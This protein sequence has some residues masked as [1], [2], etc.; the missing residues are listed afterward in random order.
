MVALYFAVEKSLSWREPKPDGNE[1][2]VWALNVR[3][4]KKLIIPGSPQYQD[5]RD[6]VLGYVILPGRRAAHS[7]LHAQDGLFT[8]AHGWEPFFLKH[9]RFPTLEEVAIDRAGKQLVTLFRK[10]AMP[11]KL[12]PD[13][14]RRL[15]S[16]RLTR[17]HLM[18]TLDNIA[19]VMRNV[20]P[21][22]PPHKDLYI[23]ASHP[24][25][26]K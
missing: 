6:K 10:I 12:A 8:W 7:F 9:G 24:H 18:P 1:I 20:E 14:L 22:L 3:E 17:Y 15:Q 16:Y 23:P 26:G 4:A 19:Y 21:R 11:A 25:N 5:M 13:I 2:V